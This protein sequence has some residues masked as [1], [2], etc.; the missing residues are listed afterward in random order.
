[1]ESTK[2]TDKTKNAVIVGYGAPEIGDDQL[3][4]AVET[5]LEY[6][7]QVS[8]GEIEMIKVFSCLRK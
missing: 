1:M 4:Q 2:I 7:K 3:K 5:T 8:G 6:I